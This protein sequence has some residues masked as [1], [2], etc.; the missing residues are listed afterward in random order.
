MTGINANHEPKMMG[1]NRKTTI[2]ERYIGCLTH[3]FKYRHVHETRNKGMP[4]KIKTE[5]E[6]AMAF[7]TVFNCNSGI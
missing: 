1:V 3:A 2:K 4:Q 7:K 6:G 5:M